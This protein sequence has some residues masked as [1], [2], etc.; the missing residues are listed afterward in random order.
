MIS[1]EYAWH[2]VY[3][4]ALCTGLGGC[5]A[6]FDHGEADLADFRIAGISVDSAALAP[7]DSVQ[8]RALVYGGEGFFH[9]E[10]PMFVWALGESTSTDALALL[11]SPSESG[12]YDLTLEVSTAA[13]EV[14]RATLAIQVSEFAQA[15]APP[16]T[17]DLSLAEVDDITVSQLKSASEEELGALLALT[18]RRDWTSTSTSLLSAD[19][20]GR[21]SLDID[22]PTERFTSHWRVTDGAGDFLELTHTDAD[23]MP[24]DVTLEDGLAEWTEDVEA[25]HFGVLALVFDGEGA[26][27]WALRD[28]VVPGD[29]DDS[30]GSWVEHG[31]R[32]LSTDAVLADDVTTIA[33]TLIAA[34]SPSGLALDEV[35]ESGSLGMS[36]PTGVGA[37]EC[38]MILPSANTFQLDWLSEGWC[39]REDVIGAR[40]I[41][42]IS[43]VATP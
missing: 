12:T 41:L 30:S 1:S 31:G 21:L 19:R 43:A 42:D 9:E 14:E 5:F 25:G 10:A 4:A 39:G 15:I 27:Q 20:V 16:T 29:G 8:A 38:P 11:E 34:E 2:F 6:P 32:W 40:V 24:M 35:E 26:V 37:L 36:D 13:G 33:A 28:V 18:A 7:G 22:D 17:L 23:W 3:V